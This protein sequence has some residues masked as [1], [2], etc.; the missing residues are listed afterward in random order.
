MG[1]T[2]RSAPIIVAA[3]LGAADFAWLDRLRREHFPPDR[4]VVPAHITVF[5]HLAP[6]LLAELD[7]RLRAEMRTAPRPVATIGEPLLLARG[8]ALRVRSEGLVAIRERL[9]DA[10]DGLLTP[11]DAAAWRPHVT[12]QNKVDPAA[13]GRLHAELTQAFPRARPLDVVGL[14]TFYYRD[15]PWEP[16][17]RYRFAG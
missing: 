8:V 15:G 2:A 6:S 17:A 7:S 3:D 16:V 5:H 9:A 4:N 1:D 12:I 11:Q 13:A 10:F 14:A